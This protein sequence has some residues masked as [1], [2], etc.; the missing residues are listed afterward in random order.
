MQF[1][2]NYS[3]VIILTLINVWASQTYLICKHKMD[4]FFIVPDKSCCDVLYVEIQECNF[5][6]QVIEVW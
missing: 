2:P 5:E 4:K 3:Q 6:L 1:I